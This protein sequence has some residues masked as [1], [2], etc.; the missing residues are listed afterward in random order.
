LPAPIAL[1]ARRV[2]LPDAAIEGALLAGDRALAGGIDGDQVAD[3]VAG[4]LAAA[5]EVV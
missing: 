4:R 5:V 3:L 2:T 1:P